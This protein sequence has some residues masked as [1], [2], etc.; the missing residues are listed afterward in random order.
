MSTA[1]SPT[2]LTVTE[3]LRNVPGGPWAVSDDPDSYDVLVTSASGAVHRVRW[4]TK[5]SGCWA[6]ADAALGAEAT[7]AIHSAL[8][9]TYSSERAWRHREWRAPDRLR[10]LVPE[11]G[12]VSYEELYDSL[13]LHLDALLDVL[14]TMSDLTVRYDGCTIVGRTPPYWTLAQR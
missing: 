10:R 11:Q 8:G 2:A 12:V 5:M 9:Y 13:W 1:L 7:G 6:I 4:I 3:S 14:D